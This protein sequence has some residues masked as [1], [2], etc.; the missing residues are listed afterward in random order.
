MSSRWIMAMPSPVR[1]VAIGTTNGSPSG[2][3]TRSTRCSTSTSTPGPAVSANMPGSSSPEV[4][5]ST[6]A[7]AAA[8]TP[9]AT[10]S[11]S[12]SRLRSRAGV[13]RR[14]RMVV[15]IGADAAAPDP[16]VF[17]AVT[18]VPRRC[19]E[20]VDDVVRVA[21][22]VG[23]DGGLDGVALEE[24]QVVD[25]D[26]GGLVDVRER[27]RPDRLLHALEDRHVAVAHPHEVVHLGPAV[28]EPAG[29]H[30]RGGGEAHPHAPQDAAADGAAAVLFD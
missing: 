17:G 21:Q 15:V 8:A 5:S 29:E 13:R 10:T 2:A 16:I 26:R 22:A 4:P 3:T 30:D 23:A 20:P 24:R 12:S 25:R 9:S 14:M 18:S 19:R 27:D 28:A 7:S 11:S 1:S 6:S